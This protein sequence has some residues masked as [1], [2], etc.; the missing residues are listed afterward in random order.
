MRVS[1]EWYLLIGSL[2]VVGALYN[3]YLGHSVLLFELILL[4]IG[5]AIALLSIRGLSETERPERG[6]GL[7]YSF[8]ARFLPKR[9]LPLLLPLFGFVLLLSWSA[10]KIMHN[11]ETNLRMEDVIVTLF[12]ISLVLYYAGPSRFQA[13]KDFVVL[14]LMFLTIVFVVIWGAYSLLSG[15]SYSRVNAY[16]EFYFITLPVVAFVRLLGVDAVAVLDLDGVG[17]S[18]TIEYFFQ[19]H[20]IRL[21]IGSGCSGLYSAGL[22]FSAFL[23]FVLVRY[24]KVDLRIVGALGLGLVLTWASNILRMVIT[25]LVGGAYGAPALALFHMYFGVLVF[26]VFIVLFWFVIV[27]WLD[28]HEVPRQLIAPRPVSEGSD[29]GAEAANV[30]DDVA[31][32]GSK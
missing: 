13:E 20:L 26:V 9:W 18:N 29:A 1:R 23:A 19:G 2:L 5:S 12:S 3:H 10:W 31:S 22:F 32:P 6:R 24:R 25:V 11:S 15:Q 7:L 14:Y 16:A 4:G 21:G 27:R 30:V 28:K 8:L 17:L